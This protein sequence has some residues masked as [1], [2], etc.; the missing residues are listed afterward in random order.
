METLK[1]QLQRIQEQLGGLSASQKMLTMSLVA[2]MVMTIVWWGRYAGHAEMVPLLDQPISGDDAAQLTQAVRAAGINVRIVGDRVMVPSERQEDALAAAGWARALPSNS[3]SGFDEMIQKIGPFETET[4]T[5]AMLNRAREM[6]LARMVSGFPGVS[7]ADVM[8]NDKSRRKIGGGG[9]IEPS[10][11]VI[12][13][14]RGSGDLRMKQLVE[15]AGA[16]VASATPGLAP[17]RV[18][19][20]VDG[21]KYRAPQ[22]SADY[23]SAELYDQIAQQEKYYSQKIEGVLQMSNVLIAVNVSIDTESR[24][25]HRETFD[26]NRVVQKETS[27]YTETLESAQPAAASQ[28]PGAQANVG[29]P[30][31]EAS[32]PQ[33]ATSTTEKNRTEMAVYPS[34]SIETVN[35]P[36]GGVRVVSAAVRV[37]FSYFVTRYKATNSSAQEPDEKTLKPMVDTELASI[38]THVMKA[39][40]LKSEDDVSVDAYWEA[41]PVLAAAD[42]VEMTTAASVGSMVTSHVKEIAIG[43]LAVVSLFMISMMVKKGTPVPILVPPMELH[44]APPL[45]ADEDIAGEVGEVGAMLDGMELDD[46]AIKAQQM[47]EQV[48]TL[49]KENPDGAANLVKRWLNK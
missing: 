8:I 17:A 34:K 23:A 5:E 4:K 26:P 18:S 10:A 11:T 9:D 33:T 40:G 28:E 1:Q 38:K 31:E 14:T 6:T 3:K 39:T 15:A 30:S 42:A 24:N 2:I 27:S 43:A 46:D 21:R 45:A 35:K 48:A 16:A 22:E 49:V 13:T 44:E 36:S 32:P 37:P 25:E 47:V 7:K 19:V 29:L 12:V 41:V 20:I